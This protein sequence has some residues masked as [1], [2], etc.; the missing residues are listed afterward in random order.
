PPPIG[1][2]PPDE[3]FLHPIARTFDGGNSRPMRPLGCRR[4]CR[5]VRHPRSTTRGGAVGDAGTQ[6]MATLHVGGRTAEFPVLPGAEGVP[7]ID[8]STLTRQTGHTAL[9]YGFVN[10]AS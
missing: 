2:A 7:S 5:A 1:C 10:T 9:D 6:E 4:G 3:G 8:I